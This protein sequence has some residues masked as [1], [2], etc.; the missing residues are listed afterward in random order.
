MFR[1]SIPVFCYH[2]VSDVD[3][4]TP[5]RFC[6]H[7]DAIQD[8]GFRT[9]SSR[10]LLRVVR[11]EMTAPDKA[12]CLTFDDGHIS[13]W[14]TV[15]PELERRG[16]TGTFFAL[17]DFTLPGEARDFSTAPAMTTMPDVFRAAYRDHDYSQF[18]NEGEIRAML[19][20]GMD[21]FSHGCRHQGAFM[22]LTPQSKMGD[23]HAHWGA[24]TL[25]PGFN[26]A[27]PV[28]K[29]G[30]GYA[31]RGF[32]P[33]LDEDGTL[34]FRLRSEN[35]RAAFCREDFRRSLERIRELNGLDEQ[36]FCWPWGQFDDLSLSEL[37][38]AGY[39]AAFTLERWVNAR[40][41][42]PYRLNRIGVGRAKTGKWVAKRLRMYGSD[43]LARV[44]FKLH[45]KRPEIGR[46]LYATDSTS[47][48]G[49]SRQMVN[50]IL[51]MRDMGVDACALVASESPLRKELEEL[52][53]T[54]FTFDG[55]RNYLRAGL[56]L[57][58]LVRREGFD[59][60]HSF[61]NRA[62]KMGVLARLMG[63]KFRLFINRG[64]NSRPNDVFFF[65][66]ALSNGVIANSGACAD[67]LQKHRVL[68]RKL[69]VVYNAYAGPDFG[70]PTMRKKRGIRMLYVGNAGHVKGFDVYLR[71]LGIYARAG[72]RDV[73]FAAVGVHDRELSQF[74]D[75]LTP[76]VRERFN[77]LG[78]LPHGE[79]LEEIRA[80]DMLVVSS[81]LESLP[82]VIVEAFN[83][84][85][86]VVATRAGGV[87]ELVQ[88]GV[89]GLLCEVEDA[90]CLAA[91][92]RELADDAS[93]RHHMGCINHAVVRSL[94]SLRNKGMHLMRV[95]LGERLMEPLPIA[96]VAARIPRRKSEEQ[97]DEH[98]HG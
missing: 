77:N 36:I 3:G 13:N 29:V 27:W 51:A 25:Y 12:V 17:T 78:H 79:V 34:S 61:H 86:P 76:E 54:V 45:R 87:P 93:R 21:V 71:A 83:L 81:R 75:L 58:D 38:R 66:T 85:L 96:E 44:F 37:R 62:Y 50:N 67:V 16:M 18:I 80:S 26:A 39:A 14:L 65:W 72:A 9:I 11:G 64:V 94:L 19:A 91:K 53:V 7:L 92:M 98:H 59:V 97:E 22:S 15:V 43:P 57:R 60:V 88:D 46:V 63:A 70:E 6:E 20:K 28:P 5:A 1:Q 69:N 73:E 33:R 47:L 89:N 2:N 35:D 55:F 56:F 90:E 8:A 4:H 31:Y 49:G 24:W 41:T 23:A 82:N 32:Q 95:Y 40:G 52:D 10:D 48:S 84:G 42:D 30:S 74:S 68:R